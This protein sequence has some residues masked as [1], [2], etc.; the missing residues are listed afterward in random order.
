MIHSANNV[1]NDA[2]GA[3]TRVACGLSVT[4]TVAGM[5]RKRE[6]RHTGIAWQVSCPRCQNVESR[7][8][9]RV[10]GGAVTRRQGQE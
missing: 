8:L 10:L 9:R 5:P 2:L 4:H 3:T 7:E 1:T 6:L